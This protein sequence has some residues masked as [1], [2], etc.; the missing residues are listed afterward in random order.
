MERRLPAGGASGWS[1]RD[2]WVAAF[3]AAF[4]L[5]QISLPIVFLVERGGMFWTGSGPATG[6]QPFS[7]QMYT[8][9]RGPGMADVVMTDGSRT[10]RNVA[11]LLG[12]SGARFVYD[13]D[14]LRSLCEA[15]PEAE[16]V[17]V[18]F[19]GIRRSVQC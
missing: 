2:I 15:I 12:E 10:E 13:D 1:R 8:V 5:S 11:A 18:V 14:G 16:S 19:T 4:V 3:V 9:V 17:S 6:E 7:W